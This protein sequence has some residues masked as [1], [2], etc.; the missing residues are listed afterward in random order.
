MMQMICST[1]E[2][3]ESMPPA[4]QVGEN[5]DPEAARQA[6]LNWATERPEELEAPA[7]VGVIMA[8]SSTFPCEE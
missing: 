2:F 1:E 7:M 5:S 8:L 4:L 3:R 6:F